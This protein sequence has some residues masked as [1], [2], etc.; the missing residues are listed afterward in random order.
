M[1]HVLQLYIL[2]YL[3]AYMIVEI[4]GPLQINMESITQN[5]E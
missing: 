2:S 4:K 3:A 1:K 5:G